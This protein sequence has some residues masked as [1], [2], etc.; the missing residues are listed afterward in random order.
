MEQVRCPL[1]HRAG[2]PDEYWVAVR[3]R[4]SH[5]KSS[6]K[7]LGPQVPYELPTDGSVKFGVACFY[8]EVC[9]KA[10]G[11]GFKN[12]SGLS[13]HKRKADEEGWEKASGTDTTETGSAAGAAA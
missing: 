4:G 1:K 10:G 3:D 13:L 7:L 5:A 8:H 12:N 11:F 9:T 2:S 6:H